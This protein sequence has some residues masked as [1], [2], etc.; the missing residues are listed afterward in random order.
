[1]CK[2]QDAGK[3]CRFELHL[4]VAVR[5]ARCSSDALDHPARAMDPVGAEGRRQSEVD[6]HDGRRKVHQLA[7]P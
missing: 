6:V 2:P 4:S 7:C 5:P 3:V 1:M